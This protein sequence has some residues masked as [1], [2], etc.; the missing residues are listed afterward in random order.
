M[1]TPRRAGKLYLRC[2]SSA[3]ILLKTSVGSSETIL[4][5]VS[6]SSCSVRN[7]G[8]RTFK[9]ALDTSW[10]DR[11]WKHYCA[12]LHSPT[13]EDRNW[14]PAQARGKG[15]DILILIGSVEHEHN[16]QG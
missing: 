10:R 14:S 16:V 8:F 9:I 7:D 4:K 2:W 13:E 5:I 11:F 12:S 3:L 15:F 6:T 1:F